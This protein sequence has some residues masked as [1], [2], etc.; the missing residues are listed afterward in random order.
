MVREEAVSTEGM[1]AGLVRTDAHMLSG[2]HHHGDYDTTIYVL[3]GKVRLECGPGGSTIVEGGPGDFL[4]LPKGAI[5]REGNP[6]DVE[7]RA[8]VVRA[9]HGPPVTNVTGPAPLA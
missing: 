8:I 9:G 6:T 4:H 3:E 5:H 1:W 2:W 7:G